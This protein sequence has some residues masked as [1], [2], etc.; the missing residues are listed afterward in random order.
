MENLNSER[1]KLVG[2]EHDLIIQKVPWIGTH[3]K[4]ATRNG[5]K[6]YYGK[7]SVKPLKTQNKTRYK[8]RCSYLPPMLKKPE[9]VQELPYGPLHWGD[10]AE[11]CHECYTQA[12]R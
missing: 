7:E 11:E 4:G 5:Y 2:S 9:A 8:H 1:R 12:R 6:L 3:K 10:P